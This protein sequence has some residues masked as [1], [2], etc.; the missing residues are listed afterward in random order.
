MYSNSQCCHEKSGPPSFSS[1]SP[2]ISKYLD[3]RKISFNFV[4]IFGPPEQ[5]FL[6]YLDPFER[7][8]PPLNSHSTHFVKGDNL[9]NLKYLILQL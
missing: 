9:F 8:N 2:N 1:P 3:P 5:K 7:F 4:E 6:I